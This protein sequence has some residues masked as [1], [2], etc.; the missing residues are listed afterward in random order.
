MWP[1]GDFERAMAALRADR[2]LL[3]RAIGNEPCDV[4]VTGMWE[5][6]R[7]RELLLFVRFVGVPF[8]VEIDP[9]EET[10]LHLRRPQRAALS[11]GALGRRNLL[12]GANGKRVGR[13]PTRGGTAEGLQGRKTRGGGCGH[14]HGGARST[15][16]A[17]G[18]HA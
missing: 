7:D 4:T 2:S 3:R 8:P 18:A 17:P 6:V 16:A 11:R 10:Y 14:S 1:T 15:G 5:V 12:R 13:S 9:D